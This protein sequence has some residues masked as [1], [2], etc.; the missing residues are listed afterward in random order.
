[1]I[2]ESM[3]ETPECKAQEVVFEWL[4]SSFETPD[5]NCD[6]CGRQ[7]KRQAS[8]FAMPF[9]GSITSRYLDRGLEG[10]YMKDGG[11]WAWKKKDTVSGKPE[12]VYIDTF[13]AQR[14]Y[15]HSE[16]LALPS[17]TTNA[18]ISADG[19][20]ITSMSQSEARQFVEHTHRETAKNSTV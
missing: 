4:A 1:M 3:C 11:H 5:P 12:P 10:G 18:T 8:R 13:Q 19:K 9:S 15:C 17:D 20:S 7:T 6:F 2:Y 16:G 14:D